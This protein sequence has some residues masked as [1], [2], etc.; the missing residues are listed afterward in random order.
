MGNC[1]IGVVGVAETDGILVAD[2]KSRGVSGTENPHIGFDGLFVFFDCF[3]VALEGVE[4]G[5]TFGVHDDG[6]FIGFAPYGGESREEFFAFCQG[7]FMFP[8][9]A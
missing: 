1:G 3:V 9:L 7:F 6:A 4:G 2:F 8:G 5:G